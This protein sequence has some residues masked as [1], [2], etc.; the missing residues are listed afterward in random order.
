MEIKKFFLLVGL[1]ILLLFPF[2][3]DVNAQFAADLTVSCDTG[4]C[5]PDDPGPLFNI[6]EVIYPGWESDAE[7]VQGVNNFSGARDFAMELTEL[8]LENDLSDVIVLTVSDGEGLI[9][10]DNLTNLQT[11]GFLILSSIDSG[12]SQN[13]Q[14]QLTMQS[15][16]G[17][18]YQDLTTE[19]DL[20]FGF[21]TLPEPSPSPE[22]SPTPT[23]TPSPSSDDGDGT[24]AGATD[25]GDGGA[26]CSVPDDLPA[27]LTATTQSASVIELNWTAA[28]DASTYNIAYGT[29]PDTY[30]YGATDIGDVSSYTVSGLSSG[31]TYYFRVYAV[32]SCG[33]GGS[34]NEASATTAGVL[35]AFTAQGPAPGFNVLGEA[36][37]SAQPESMKLQTPDEG[38]EETGQV[39][40]EGTSCRWWNYWWWLPLVI[41]GV[42][43]LG[44]RYWLKKKQDQGEEVLWSHYLFFVFL[45]IVSQIIHIILGCWC[46]QSVWCSR[47]WL[48][49]LG[50]VL[51][52][53]FLV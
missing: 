18:E 39:K 47:Y 38:G 36:T 15:S 42:L 1:S 24:V 14:F 23:P 26:S 50:I 19:F 16:A 49:N 12:A 10:Q 41:Q 22:V 51:L 25:D 17:N 30:I 32:N 31:T 28:G 13:Y 35:G 52:H 5:T 45:G 53:L 4:G 48:L 11:R 33:A 6:E 8:T 43:S 3:R 9:Y 20:N 44:Y 7:F 27:G 46:V 37:E 34:S 21:D 29:A 40:G 2:T